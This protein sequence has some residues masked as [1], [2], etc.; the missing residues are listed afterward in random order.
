MGGLAQVAVQST[1]EDKLMQLCFLCF[2]A[3]SDLVAAY[4]AVEFL[5]VSDLVSAYTQGEFLQVWSWATA[6][7]LGEE[8]LLVSDSVSAYTTEEGVELCEVELPPGEKR[9]SAGA[10][11]QR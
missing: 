1:A 10:V 3:M 2:L 11:S 8:L 5:L 4:M 7:S 9:D 6:Y